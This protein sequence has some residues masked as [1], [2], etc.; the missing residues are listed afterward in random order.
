MKPL[1]PYAKSKIKLENYIIRNS[2]I[3]NVEYIILRYFNVVG[4]D[5]K[6]R[7]GLIS[8]N[9]TNL[10]KVICD[11]ATK[12][13]DKLTINGIDYKTK[14]GTTIRDY[15]H[16]SDL[17]EIHS[18]VLNYLIKKQKSEIF[19]C[20]YGKGFSILDVVKSINKI[21][22]KKIQI[23]FGKPRKNDIER[24]VANINKFNKY[25]SWKPKYNNL[26]SILKTSLEWDKNKSF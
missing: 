9:S 1:N 7:T 5:K 2:K 24:S 23:K 16:V 3:K 22:K 10:I 12:K 8:K 18:L 4:A 19:N 6:L 15:I 13:K 21:L 20:G 17:A 26:S 11:V 25:I 14:D